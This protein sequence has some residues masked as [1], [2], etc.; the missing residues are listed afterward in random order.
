MTTLLN[1]PIT[2]ISR[3]QSWTV[4]VVNDVP[5]VVLLRSLQFGGEKDYP[6][7]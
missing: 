1:Y 6:D 3:T 5:S 2:C 4:V 7:V